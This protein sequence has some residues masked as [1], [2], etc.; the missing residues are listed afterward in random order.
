MKYLYDTNELNNILYSENEIFNLPY[1]IQIQNDKDKK[2]LYKLFINPLDLKIENE[3][4]YNNLLKEGV[5][6]VY[7]NNSKSNINYKKDKNFFEFY[8]LDKLEN[9]IL[10]MKVS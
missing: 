10:F 9:Q 8:Y 7:F 4:N 6:S 2:F 3:H 1:S 5:S